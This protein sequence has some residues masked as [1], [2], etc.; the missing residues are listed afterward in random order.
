[1][2]IIITRVKYEIRSL[3]YTTFYFWQMWSKYFHF[4]SWLKKWPSGTIYIMNELPVYYQDTVKKEFE[5]KQKQLFT[6]EKKADISYRE[7][8]K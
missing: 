3:S 1:M 6:E 5:V 2:G 8:F 4:Y 7:K